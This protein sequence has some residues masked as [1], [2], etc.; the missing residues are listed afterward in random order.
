[1]GKQKVTKLTTNESIGDFTHVIRLSAS[2]M[3]DAGTSTITFATIPAGAGVDLAM[4]TE[5]VAIEGATDI[6]LDVGTAS[7]VDTLIDNLDVDGANG[8]PVANTG[9]S[10]VQG[11]GNTTIAGGSLPVELKASDTAVTYTLGGSVSSIT[12]GELIIG[13]RMIDLGRFTEASNI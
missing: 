1:M 4:A 12:G 9:T 5:S 10:F 13:I 3:V 2:D 11:A 8:T 6:T 7:D